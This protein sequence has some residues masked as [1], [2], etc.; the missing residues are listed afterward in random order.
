M[1]K[2]TM[3]GICMTLIAVAKIGIDV[4]NGGGFDFEGNFNELVVAL[5]GL[6]IVFGR[7]A[8]SKLENQAGK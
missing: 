1:N 8:I 7:K 3:I 2:T 5:G 6:G 4:L